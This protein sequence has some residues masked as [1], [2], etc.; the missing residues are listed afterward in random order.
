[1]L[2]QQYV[3]RYEHLDK[4]RIG[5]LRAVLLEQASALVIDNVYPAKV[6]GYEFDIELHPGAQPV[7]HQLPKTG[8]PK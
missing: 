4:T 5:K 8:P 3:E 2:E 1:M 6:K 7:R